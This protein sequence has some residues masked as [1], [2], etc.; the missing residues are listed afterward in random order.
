MVR[1][2]TE[3]AI[4]MVLLVPFAAV[5]CFFSEINPFVRCVRCKSRATVQWVT[6]DPVPHARGMTMVH[7]T[8]KCARCGERSLEQ[9]LKERSGLW[10]A[11]RS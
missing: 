10:T 7:R 5:F 11:W 3:W 2:I 6:D 1:Y 4:V 9:K 8:T